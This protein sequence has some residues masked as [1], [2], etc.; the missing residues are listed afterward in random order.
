[1][2]TPVIFAPMDASHVPQVVEIERLASVAPWSAGL[3]LHELKVSF[4][5]CRVACSANGTRAVV[6][7]ACWWVVAEEA[8]VLNIAVHPDH[9]RRG[10]GGALVELVIEDARRGGARSISLEVRPDNTAARALYGRF[11]FQPAGVRRDYYGRGQDALIMT[12]EL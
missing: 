12:R 9:R 2:A 5:R 6:G 4:S 1:M 10:I 3:F 8:H 11:G 7:F